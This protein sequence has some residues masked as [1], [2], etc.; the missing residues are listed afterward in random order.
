MPP[1]G[2]N[3]LSIEGGS[4]RPFRAFFIEGRVTHGV[5]VGWRVKCTFGA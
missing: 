3:G 5:A 2:S 4:E 1:A